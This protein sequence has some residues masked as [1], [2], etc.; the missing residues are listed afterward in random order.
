MSDTVTIT[1]PVSTHVLQGLGIALL[2]VAL[3]AITF[4]ALP[5]RHRKTAS[6]KYNSL[7]AIRVLATVLAPI[8]LWL[9]GH[10]LWSLWSLAQDNNPT[11]QDNDLRWHILAFV[12]LITALG[13]MVSAPLALIRVWTTERQTRTAEQGHIT[14][15]ISKAVEQLGAEK[16]VKRQ[17]INSAGKKVFRKSEN[18]KPDYAQPVLVDETL[19]NIEVRIGGLLSLER[20]AQDSVRYDE[21]RDHVRVMEILCAYVRENAPASEA[22]QGIHHIYEKETKNTF[23]APGLEHYEF[24]EKY[25][26][27]DP[28]HLEWALSAHGIRTWASTLPRPREDINLR[29]V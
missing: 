3:S 20:I 12:G 13:A 19:P 1:L 24:M 27:Q 29:N 9:I 22:K 26:F 10:I 4:F 16:T 15:R 25:K 18:G 14:D 8:W 17:L 23:D 7:H 11:V 2:F 5:D 6:G 28:D 21:G